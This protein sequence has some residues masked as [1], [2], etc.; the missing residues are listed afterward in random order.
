MKKKYSMIESKA[1]FHS[2]LWFFYSR[3]TFDHMPLGLLN[4]HC[5]LSRVMGEQKEFVK[6]LDS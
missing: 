6:P 4:P 3:L 2:I 1:E 5:V